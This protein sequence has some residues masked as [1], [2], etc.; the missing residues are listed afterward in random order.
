MGVYFDALRTFRIAYL[1]I[2][3]DVT[4]W[5]STGTAQEGEQA[6]KKK[7]STDPPYMGEGWNKSIKHHKEMG[8]LLNM[9]TKSIHINH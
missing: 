2:F 5:P 6:R 8:H 7:G 9:T 1:Q 3:R 4:D